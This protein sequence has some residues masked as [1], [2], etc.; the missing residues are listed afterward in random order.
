MAGAE[1]LPP[2]KDMMKQIDWDLSNKVLSIRV[3]TCTVQIA[4]IHKQAEAFDKIC[5]LENDWNVSVT[6]LM[7]QLVLDNRD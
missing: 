7:K 4:N 2:F 5:Q 6:E 1:R 3:D